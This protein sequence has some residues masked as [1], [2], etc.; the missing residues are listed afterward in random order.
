MLQYIAIAIGASAGI[1][2]LAACLL[3]VLAGDL[4]SDDFFTIDDNA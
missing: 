3:C 2:L 1:A 4:H